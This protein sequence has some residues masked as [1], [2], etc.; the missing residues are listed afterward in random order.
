MH[1]LVLKFEVLNYTGI[2]PQMA[3]KALFD[4]IAHLKTETYYVYIILLQKRLRLVNGSSGCA[5][6]NSQS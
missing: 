1:Q 4:H 2:A 3:D 6:A 5:P